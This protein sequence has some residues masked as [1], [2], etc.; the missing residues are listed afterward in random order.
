M[1]TLNICSLLQWYHIKAAKKNK[2][3]KKQKK[4]TLKENSLSRGPIGYE[5]SQAKLYLWNWD[6]NCVKSF[7]TL[8][9]GH[10]DISEMASLKGLN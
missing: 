7:N 9:T 10:L 5:L 8:S 2:Q 1:Y 3:N 4:K 6:G